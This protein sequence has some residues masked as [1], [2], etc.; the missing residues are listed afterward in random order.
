MAGSSRPSSGHICGKSGACP[1]AH[2]SSWLSTQREL[3]V[4]KGSEAIGVRR[5][6][7]R[8]EPALIVSAIIA[9]LAWRG[10]GLSRAAAATAALALVLVLLQA[11]YDARHADSGGI[12]HAGPAA[13]RR[14]VHDRP[15]RGAPRRVAAAL[16]R[17]SHVGA[18]ARRPDCVCRL[19]RRDLRSVRQGRTP[20]VV[21]A[22]AS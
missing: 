10:A 12:A 19:L 6:R 11:W 21:G 18:A 20:G 16:A 22:G 3:A 15:Q 14:P 5:D 7:A 2:Q 4:G 1:E 13:N 8:F 9:L 17:A